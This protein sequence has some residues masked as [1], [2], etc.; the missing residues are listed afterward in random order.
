MGRIRE[1]RLAAKE[2]MRA[3]NNI[4]QQMSTDIDEF[5]ADRILEPVNPLTQKRLWYPD[6]QGYTRPFIVDM[7]T[8]EAHWDHAC[9]SPASHNRLS[10][11]PDEGSPLFT[12]FQ[13]LSGAGFSV[14]LNRDSL[15]LASRYSL[16][17]IVNWLLETRTKQ[18]YPEPC[19]PLRHK[20]HAHFGRLMSCNKTIQRILAFGS[21]VPHR[22]VACL[23][24]DNLL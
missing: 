5:K 24:V 23:S 11:C 13:Y 6:Q 3:L 16:S 17:I 19:W 20:I 22:D 4:L 10:I 18:T 12:V 1:E 7:E 14:H 15:Q 21:A 8:G 9:D 2:Q